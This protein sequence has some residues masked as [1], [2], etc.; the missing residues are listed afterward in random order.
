MCRWIADL[1]GRSLQ[2]AGWAQRRP[3]SGGV[4]LGLVGLFLF[5]G[6][7]WVTATACSQ[8]TCCYYE[9]CYVIS[10]KR[11]AQTCQL[12]PVKSKAHS[13]LS[14]FWLYGALAPKLPHVAH[15]WHED[16][17]VLSTQKKRIK[18]RC[19]NCI[20]A[21]VRPCVRPWES[22]YSNSI[23]TANTEGNKGRFLLV[24][25]VVLVGDFIYLS[26]YL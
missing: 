15:S 3:A 14:S 11:S 16:G 23:C 8:I 7:S 26:V 13:S 25:P 4:W 6:W 18:T 20:W 9:A 19:T 24:D 5:Q 21:G 22:C 1:G 17:W 12:S 10:G 2:D